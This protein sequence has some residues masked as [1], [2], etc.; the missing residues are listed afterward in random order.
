MT[1]EIVEAD[2]PERIE[3]FRALLREYA[4]ERAGGF[5]ERM[6]Q[7]L[8][9]LPGRYTPPHG[10]MYLALYEGRPVGTAA[11]TEHT[12]SLVELK[13]VYVQPA[14][15]GRGIGRALSQ[16]VIREVARRGYKRVGISTWATAAPAIELYRRLGFV[17]IP[18]F[19]ATTI[20][21]IVYL[22]LD[23]A[24]TQLVKVS[25]ADLDDPAFAA[26]FADAIAKLAGEGAG[27]VVVHGGGKE[28]TQLLTAM[29]VETRFVDGLRV[30]DA[31]TR[32]AAL[33]V[34]SGLA[35]KRLVAALLA[36]GV[37]AIGVSGV[38]AGLIRVEPLRRE[39]EFVG[40]P[41]SVRTD[42]LTGWLSQ[43][44]VPVIAPMSV[45]NDGDIYNV[46]ADHVAGAVAV[47]LDASMLTF[48]TNV[49][50]VL[51]RQKSLIPC[52]T[53]AQAEAL[54]ADGV[55]YGGMI[56]KVRSALEALE[57]GVSRV[58]ITNLDGLQEN[59]GTLI[60]K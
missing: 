40:R 29:Q 22:G 28:L 3:Q 43:G 5:S 14:Y 48:V 13:R 47:A 18:P 2:A 15:R 26:R 19:K 21:N 17:E 49:P 60:V 59:H 54:I 41:V 31:R 32:D 20:P 12:P 50:G 36:R 38:D 30:S 44:L 42:L 34:L 58:R 8:R 7:D 51:D 45:G 52:L 6:T 1:I 53:Y 55:V 56:P 23:M 33:M 16:H 10:E 57:S 24:E 11:W 35:N 4:A 39:L 46:N 9:D 25:G 37:H 27:V